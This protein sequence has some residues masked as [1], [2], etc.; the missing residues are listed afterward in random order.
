[1]V[2]IGESGYV[3][4]ERNM[5]NLRTVAVF[6]DDEQLVQRDLIEKYSIEPRI[7]KARHYD[8]L[9]RIMATGRV[10][11][12]TI[13]MNEFHKSLISI[14]EDRDKFGQPFE[15]GFKESFLF[16]SKRRADELA[17]LMDRLIQAL[18]DMKS[19][20]TVKELTNKF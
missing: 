4:H 6:V 16:L 11:A 12:I 10:T 13:P 1:M 17:P 14:N 20:G 5:L 18:E 19:D 7:Q 15:I 8:S 2:L 9:V 3:I